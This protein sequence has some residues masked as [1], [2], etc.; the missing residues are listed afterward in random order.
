[1][2]GSARVAQMHLKLLYPS[3]VVAGVLQ[4]AGSQPDEEFESSGKPPV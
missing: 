3:N 2:H 1:M 4:V